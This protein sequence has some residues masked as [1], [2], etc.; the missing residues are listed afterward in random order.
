MNDAVVDGIAEKDIIKNYW[1][2][3][4]IKRETTFFTLT[5]GYIQRPDLLSIKLF[6]KQDYWWII[7]K[8]NPEIM[9]WWNDIDT[10]NN[11]VIVVPDIRDIEDWFSEVRKFKV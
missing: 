5:R 3:F 6:G 2:L 1:E 10:E 4:R 7:A 11:Q 9:D 8:V